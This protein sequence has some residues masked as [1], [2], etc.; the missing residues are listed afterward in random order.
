MFDT[1]LVANRGEI[2]CRVFRTA[3]RLGMRTVAVYSEADHAALHVAMADDA[4]CIGPAPAAQSYLLID[5]VIAAAQQSGAQAVHPGYGFLSEN[6]DFADACVSA[7]LT[8]VGPPAQAIR[9]M[10]SKTASKQLMEAS[11]VPILPGYH[12]NEQDPDFLAEQAEAVGYPLLIKASAGGGGKGMRLVEDSGAFLDQ[13]AGAKREALAAFADDQVLLERYLTSPKHIEVQL[14]AD[15]HG[16]AVH[17]FERDCSVQRRHQKVIEE[18]PGPTVTQEMRERL[19]STAVQAAKGVGYVGAGTVEFIAEGDEF[20]FMEMNTRLQVEHPVTE[21]ITGLDLVELQ[22]KVA[23]GEP[24]P[25][26]QAD[27]SLTG[28][29][30]EARLYAENPGKKFLPSTGRVVH[31]SIADDVR[32]DTGIRSGD[33]VTMHYDPML[34]KI[35][36]H[37]ANR[38]EAIASLS[39]ALSTSEVA[40]VEHNLGYL[41]GMLAQP[42][43]V[44]GSY[45]TGLAET[46]HEEVVPQL[47]SQA[48]VFA[49]L[50]ELDNEAADSGTQELWSAT[51]GLRL[52]LPP[53]QRLHLAQGKRSVSVDIR[54]ESVVVGDEEFELDAVQAL[55]N[56]GY[57]IRLGG[58]NLQ[59]RVIR[60]SNQLYVMCQGHTE[61][62]TVL[63]DDL[64]RY[65]GMALN[66]GG[67]VAPMPGQVIAV[68][69][70]VGDKVKQGDVLAVVEAMKMEHS[71]TAPKDGTVAAVSCRVGD[72]VEEGV[73]LVEL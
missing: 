66:Q 23:A 24:L 9:T 6:A 10:G 42:A 35:I 64:S 28:H 39:R 7:G 48:A 18:A 20:F 37:G 67:I 59:A 4:I 58:H 19:G 11:A 22:L 1:L 27:V 14:M 34:A 60:E 25:V 63:T 3:R 16:N 15:T 47:K 55:G 53:R 26:A 72:R 57:R 50:F 61:R 54:V 71:I 33:E 13:L 8:F 45:T 51:R 43:F 70:K 44:D 32:I 12:G 68:S 52:N 41:H 49:T 2:A 38:A 73:V 21:A 65:T 62:F 17:L 40:G 29:A 69:V 56:G 30:I 5:E 36:A 46:V 31:F